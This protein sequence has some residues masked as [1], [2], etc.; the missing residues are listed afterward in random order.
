MF[1]MLDDIFPDAP[2]RIFFFFFNWCTCSLGTGDFAY[3]PLGLLSYVVHST[4]TG[5]PLLQLTIATCGKIKLFNV[6]ELNNIVMKFSKGCFGHFVFF[7]FFVR[8]YTGVQNIQ[9]YMIIHFCFCQN[10]TVVAVL[11]KYYVQTEFLAL[12]FTPLTYV[13]TCLNEV[14]L[15]Y[16]WQMD[17]SDVGL[18][19][20]IALKDYVPLGDD[21]LPLQKD[22]EYILIKSSHPDWWTVKDD[23]G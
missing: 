5:G 3:L 1:C 23:Q 8:K 12:A 4:V 16:P 17:L 10:P 15:F 18:R 7:V 2:H 9:L 19:L 14:F 21:D 11:V 20:V 22:Q 6:T 13:I